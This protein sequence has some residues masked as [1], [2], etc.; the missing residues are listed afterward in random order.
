LYLT[1]FIDDSAVRDGAPEPAMEETVEEPPIRRYAPPPQPKAATAW[2]TPANVGLLLAAIAGVGCWFGDEHFT[3][4]PTWTL[5][6]NVTG[7]APLL[8]QR[9]QVPVGR[10]APSVLLFSILAVVI[11]RW[12]GGTAGSLVRRVEL[13]V[14]TSITAALLGV[15]AGCIDFWLL[16]ALFQ[17]GAAQ[18]IAL[19]LQDFL[20]VAGL[21]RAEFLAHF[22][23][24]FAWLGPWIVVFDHA[25]H[26]R[27]PRT[28]QRALII[29]F[30]LTLPQ[31]VVVW[32]RSWRGLITERVEAARDFISIGTRTILA[33]ML[34]A[35]LQAVKRGI[36]V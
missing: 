29:Y 3:T 11:A 12:R 17:L 4:T 22:L 24:L 9:V 13:I 36:V 30:V 31:F 1:Y 16:L 35:G 7:E 27:I 25:T 33:I 23:A 28:L 21:Y 18:A 15:L 32:F 10:V 8:T 5:R 14:A 6:L 19:I 20:H 2:C 26:T 34:T